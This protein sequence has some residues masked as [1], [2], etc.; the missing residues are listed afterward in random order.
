MA[1]VWLLLMSVFLTALGISPC[2]GYYSA[3]T[4]LLNEQHSNHT[5]IFYFKL[6]LSA[7]KI[8]NLIFQIFVMGKLVF[9]CKS[10]LFLYFWVTQFSSHNSWTR[11][12]GQVSPETLGLS[13]KLRHTGLHT[14]THTHTH[15]SKCVWHSASINW[16]FTI[17]LWQKHHYSFHL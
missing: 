5:S 8:N 4:C 6:A 14:H 17:I 15:T 1:G 16:C 9:P 13:A 7:S 10:S 11:I 2:I 3:D 12:L